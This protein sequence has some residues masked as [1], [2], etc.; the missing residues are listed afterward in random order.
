MHRFPKNI[1]LRKKWLENLDMAD[2][3]PLPT[4][5]KRLCNLHF[6]EEDIVLYPVTG[7]R[8]LKPDA[9]PLK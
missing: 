2:V 9:M 8:G 5:E 4:I 1:E 3:S 7:R 6:N